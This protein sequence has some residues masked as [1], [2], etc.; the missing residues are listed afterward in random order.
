M[1]IATLDNSAA[2]DRP[3]AEEEDA[4]LVQYSQGEHDAALQTTQD[5]LVKFPDHHL[6]WKVAGYIYQS[7]N[8]LDQA[9]VHLEQAVAF[10]PQDASDLNNLGVLLTDLGRLQEAQAHF[11]RAVAI[12][13]QYGKA[14]TNLAMVFQLTHEYA[15]AQ[16]AAQRAVSLDETDAA[17]LIQLGN[18]FEAQGQLSQ[19]QASYYRAD[20]AHEPRR[21][22]AHSNVLYLMNHDVL[23]EPEHLFAEHMA[24]GE[25][26]ETA[27]RGEWRGHGNNPDPKR[28]LRVGFV[29]GDFCQ[30]ALNAFLEPSFAALAQRPLLELHAYVCNLH[31]DATTQR[32]HRY[33]ARWH[34]VSTLSD[35]ALAEKIRADGIDI[36]FD[37]SGHT[38]RNRLLAFAHKPAPIQLSWLGYLGSTGLQ[39]MDGY[40]AD[41]YWIPPE[42]SWQF[43]EPI[44]YL[45]SPVVFQPETLAP[46][47]NTLPAL[48]NGYLTFGSFNRI[49]KINDAVIALWSLL[50]QAL[51]DSRLVLGGIEVNDEALL[52][53]RFASQGVD[54]QRLHCH[55][56]HSTS[57]YLALHHHVDLC[58]DSFPHGGG[59]TTAYA[60]WMG[61]PTL[62]LAGDVPASRFSASLMHQLGLD[63]FVTHCIED[64]V[65]CGVHWAGQ[66]AELATL[67]A[68]LRQHMQQSPLGRPQEFAIQMEA[69]LRGHWEQW[70]ASQASAH[71]P[72]DLAASLIALGRTH[73]DQDRS[74]AAAGLYAEA[75][76]LQPDNANAHYR[77]GQIEVR[78]KRPHAALPHLEAAVQHQPEEELHWLAYINALLQSGAVATAASAIEWG[79]K[80]GLRAESALQISAKCVQA[81]EN[82]QNPAPVLSPYTEEDLAFP[83]CPPWPEPRTS[84]GAELSYIHP[85]HSKHRRYVIYAPLYRHNSAGIRVLYE[86]QKWLLLAGQDA[87]VIAATNSYAPGQFAD[88]IVVYPEVVRGNPL[89]A[90]R[91]VRYILNVP[92]KIG[93]TSD[94]APNELCVAYVAE[95]GQYAHGR[96]L[97]IPMIESFF[98]QDDTP[99]T[100]D[101]FYIGK[102]Q[103]SQAHPQD[104]VAITGTF[105]TTRYAMAQFLRSVRTLYSYDNF[106]ALL[107]EAQ[108]CGATVKVIDTHG[109]WATMPPIPIPSV[110]DVQAQLHDFIEI[111]T[112]L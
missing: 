103:N 3:T 27:L 80:F 88:D 73:E 34:S 50:L 2:N 46:P 4:L 60:A 85:P 93:G 91:V 8:Q 24:F 107:G 22:V 51:P 14:W 112:R 100:T 76:K 39:A 97:S 62:C 31:E 41:N 102:G 106:T 25:Q 15:Q 83:P 21:A 35:M 74:E 58:L 63:A 28:R 33:F 108:L 16:A 111:T 94:Y 20:M 77:L 84:L 12:V 1:T 75:L 69:L 64:F 45:P 87:I 109:A 67:R 105:P 18:A 5:W 9:L 71:R 81:M 48:E 43:C 104:C 13:P 23:V 54:T 26:F 44:A 17:A 101:A 72:N 38:A 65:Q 11:E 53:E 59:A 78:L 29:S 32:M 66:M 7:R 95:L 98:Y 19:A 79:Q 110:I 56:R 52:L 49:S 92:G 37:L 70:C 82:L 61:V 42:L 10:G 90:R 55:P 40:I 96:L 99:K 6:G 47:V 36:L 86:L 89:H 68:G 57:A 30:H